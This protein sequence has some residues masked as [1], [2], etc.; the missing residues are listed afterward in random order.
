VVQ[1]RD[2]RRAAAA[3]CGAAGYATRR[4]LSGVAR[5]SFWALIELIL[6]VIVMIFVN[7]PGGS[8]AYSIPGLVIFAGL[9]MSDFQR[10]R[11]L[12]GH[13]L[14]AADGPIPDVVDQVLYVAAGRWAA[15]SPDAVLTTQSLSALY[16]TRIDVIRVHGHIVIVGGD[17]AGG[18]THP[19]D[20]GPAGQA[21]DRHDEHTG[22]SPEGRQH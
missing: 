17:T 11:P 15:G 10:L 22:H 6:S 13:R 20:D 7:I 3:G 12:E 8:L 19:D 9:T 5:A 18:C 4:D 2:D 14:R 16:G 1:R 21:R